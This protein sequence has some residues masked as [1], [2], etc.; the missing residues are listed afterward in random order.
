M[1]G[2]SFSPI[3]NASLM[4]NMTNMEDGQHGAAID[5]SGDQHSHSLKMSQMSGHGQI[6]D[7]DDYNCMVSDACA[8]HCAGL[9]V[10]LPPLLNG[11][12]NLNKSFDWLIPTGQVPA[13]LSSFTLDRPPRS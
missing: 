4:S 1:A 13:F 2:V 7:S 9:A 8:L 6:T 3:A 5:K 12:V 11:L 10:P